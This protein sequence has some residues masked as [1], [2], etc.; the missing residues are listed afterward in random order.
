MWFLRDFLS[1]FVGK[2]WNNYI[3]QQVH[4]M[5]CLYLLNIVTCVVALYFPMKFSTSQVYF[6]LCVLCESLCNVKEFFRNSLDILVKDW[7]FRDLPPSQIPS[8][9]SSLYQVIF[10][11]GLPFVLHLRLIE[12]PSLAITTGG[13]LRTLGFLGAEIKERLFYSFLSVWASPW[14]LYIRPPS[15]SMIEVH[16]HKKKFQTKCF[17]YLTLILR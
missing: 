9:L 14:H 8:S 6:P 3:E 17:P 5:Y 10:G 13:K 4:C 15:C 12:I 1:S 16:V 7:Q 2:F 11:R